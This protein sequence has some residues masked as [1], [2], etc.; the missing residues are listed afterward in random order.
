[1][2]F[3]IAMIFL[4]LIGTI[5]STTIDGTWMTATDVAPIWGLMTQL[6][7]SESSGLI[8][9]IVGFITVPWT[10]VSFLWTVLSWNYGF[11]TDA[12]PWS[13]LRYFGWALS[14]GMVYSVMALLRGTTT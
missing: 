13:M 4:Y 11:L 3:L 12:G 10:F 1:M 7:F 5:I 6:G 14:I 2:Y 8:Q 9:G